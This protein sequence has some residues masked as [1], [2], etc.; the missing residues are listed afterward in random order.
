MSRGRQVKI[1]T[2]EDGGVTY[3][4]RFRQGGTETSR[5]FRKLGDANTFVAILDSDP[6]SGVTEALSWLATK[7][8]DAEAQT[9]GEYVDTYVSQLTGVTP[10]TRADYLA[11][12][13]RYFGALQAVPLPLVTRSHVSALVNGLE[14]DLSAKTIK[15]VIHLLSSIMG[16]AVDDRLIDRNPCRRVRLPQNEVDGIE[17]R[18]L[19]PH[20]FARLLAEIP[21]HY[22]SLVLFLVGTGA[23]WSEATAL[24]PRNVHLDRGTVRIDRAWKWQGK[25]AGWKVGPPKS[26]KSRR[27]VNA[28]VIALKAVAPLPDGDYVF[29]TPTGKV[30]RHNNFYSRVWL[31]AV[32]R[33]GLVDENDNPIRIHDLRHTHASWLISDGQS[34]EAV[35]DQLG[36]ESILTTRKVYGHLQPAVGVAVGKSASET[37]AR[38]LGQP[39]QLAGRPPVLGSVQDAHEPTDS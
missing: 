22:K 7:E 28:A 35:Q 34:L 1:H 21:D 32:G 20:E 39:P 23:R 16:M 5:T 9:F 36:H 15:N 4:V 27:T 11:I 6:K 18:F 25:G 37:L 2:A 26:K 10:R 24:T 31:P 14:G 12:N 33:A 3:R 17:A 29:T 19:E 13:R 30:V 38:A 8:K